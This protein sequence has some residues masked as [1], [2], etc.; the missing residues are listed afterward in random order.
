MEFSKIVV[1]AVLAGVI[2][3]SSREGVIVSY[4]ILSQLQTNTVGQVLFVH[5]LFVHVIFMVGGVVGKV[6]EGLN[7]DLFKPEHSQDQFLSK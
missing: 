3:Q 6:H 7:H 2:Q 5:Q 4:F 1:A